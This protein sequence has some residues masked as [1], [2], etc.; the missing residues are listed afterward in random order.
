MYASSVAEFTPRLLPLA[1]NFS[2]R[3]SLRLYCRVLCARPDI[4]GFQQ[5]VHNYMRQ[6]GG[7]EVAFVV[8]SVCG[9]FR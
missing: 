4:S 6:L 1:A 2:S 5:V 3:P 7:V 8:Q 9:G